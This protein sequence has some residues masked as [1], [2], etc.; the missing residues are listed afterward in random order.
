MESEVFMMRVI[1]NSKVKP[2]RRI[3]KGFALGLI[4]PIA[5][6]YLI[7]KHIIKKHQYK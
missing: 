4:A 7:H 3:G 6:V 5:T 2:Q 1:E